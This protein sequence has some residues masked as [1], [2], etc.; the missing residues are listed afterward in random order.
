M[1]SNRALRHPTPPQ[2]PLHSV[3]PRQKHVH[4]VCTPP[5]SPST[6]PKVFAVRMASA[7]TPMWGSPVKACS[8][9]AAPEEPSRP[10]FDGLQPLAYTGAALGI[11]PVSFRP[12]RLS[13]HPLRSTLLYALLV[14]SFTWWEL[15]YVMTPW[16]NGQPTAQD[17]FP[18]NKGFL[19]VV[20]CFESVHTTVHLTGSVIVLVFWAEVHKVHKIRSSCGNLLVDFGYVLW[21]RPK[22]PG[23][24]RRP[25]HGLV[26]I[27]TMALWVMPGAMV[28][29]WSEYVET[30]VEPKNALAHSLI[31]AQLGFGMI[32][33]SLC[34]LRLHSFATGLLSELRQASLHVSLKIGSR[35]GPLMVYFVLFLRLFLD[36]S[37]D[38][39]Y[40]MTS[41]YQ[42]SDADGLTKRF[43]CPQKI[44]Q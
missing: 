24:R 40:F 20:S 27:T 30:G 44:E 38:R 6:T 37:Q 17:K 29:L 34:F 14:Q 15:F 19:A 43:A 12:L 23:P 7:S 31:N 13:F 2:R 18:N 10:F 4:F 36:S 42:Q 25:Q 3:A 28:I 1:A 11:V 33:L 32:V 16:R 22:Q 39:L 5:D 8:V 35:A 21:G 26:W 9:A 41:N